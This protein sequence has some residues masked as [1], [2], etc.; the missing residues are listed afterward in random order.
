VAATG[1][2]SLQKAAQSSVSAHSMMDMV[3]FEMSEDDML[4][5]LGEILE[6]G[7][8]DLGELRMLSFLLGKLGGSV[9]EVMMVKIGNSIQDF[10]KD[11]TKNCKSMEEMMA[12][13][14]EVKDI[15]AEGAG[16]EDEGTGDL[17]ASSAMSGML[18]IQ[19]VNASGFLPGNMAKSLNSVGKKM[20]G[21]QQD[22]FNDAQDQF[23]QDMGL[24]AMDDMIQDMESEGDVDS[25]D[26]D[27]PMASK[28]KKMMPTP[29]QPSMQRVH[30]MEGA[31]PSQGAQS[32][33]SKVQGVKSK[34]GG[35]QN[36]KQ[37]QP[38]SSAQFKQI[39]GKIDQAFSENFPKF[40]SEVLDA[41]QAI[42]E[43]KLDD[44]L[45]QV[46]AIL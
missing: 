42:V 32:S 44:T 21:M 10:V 12:F 1:G 9:N 26:D 27:D 36:G 41:V 5:M 43:D 28:K 39:N 24:N 11:Q 14:A 16:T 40:A 2:G 37:Q 18:N 25:S 31:S 45:S 7:I 6:G 23:L 4:D 34:G 15:M 46:E 30:K 19:K 13:M 22:Q 35:F 29:Q 20:M 33:T 17:L 38:G 8:E 3:D